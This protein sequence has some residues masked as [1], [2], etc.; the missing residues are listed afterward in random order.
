M[1]VDNFYK[2]FCSTYAQLTSDFEEL[3][4]KKL[5]LDYWNTTY[6]IKEEKIRREQY[7]DINKW[8]EIH[9]VIV[10]KYLDSTQS[11]T[12]WCMGLAEI[13]RKFK[14]MVEQNDNINISND[15]LDD[16]CILSD[17]M[18]QKFLIE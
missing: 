10:D 6:M 9:D 1:K 4:I 17:L 2:W 14:A 18:D 16:F 8:L 13:E 12:G 11:F 3:F 7:L 5:N 15:D